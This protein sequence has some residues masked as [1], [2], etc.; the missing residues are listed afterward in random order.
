[1]LDRDPA[2]LYGV[3]VRVINQ[4]VKWDKARF[5]EDFSFKRD[6]MDL[7]ETKSQNVI[8]RDNLS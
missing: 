1:M 4:T 3:E 6:S 5:P 7:G 8:L 2:E